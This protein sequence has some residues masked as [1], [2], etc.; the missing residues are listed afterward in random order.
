MPLKDTGVREREQAGKPS[1]HDASL[2][3]WKETGKE[4]GAG[5]KRLG[6]KCSSENFP[7]KREPQLARR[8]LRASS[9][10]SGFSIAARSA[11]CGSIGSSA[12]WGGLLHTSLW[13]ADSQRFRRVPVG[14]PL[15]C[16]FSRYSACFTPSLQLGPTLGDPVDCSPPGSSVHGILQAR[17]LERVAMPASWAS[18]QPRDRTLLSCTGRQVLHH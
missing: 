9:A 12:L 18:S 4:G 17:K 5:R 10:H 16:T 3:P 13:V 1:D 2:T 8:R 6:L 14:Q 11:Q 15:C 7:A